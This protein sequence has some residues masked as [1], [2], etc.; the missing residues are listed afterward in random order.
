M[1][2][3]AFWGLSAL[4]L[5][6]ATAYAAML[7]ANR[8]G[9]MWGFDLGL[10]V[11][12]DFS[13]YWAAAQ[14]AADGR[15]IEIFDRTRFWEMRQDLLG[16][17]LR[18]MGAWLYPPH[19]LM[20]LSPLAFAPYLAGYALFIG[21]TLLAY[22]YAAWR[23]AIRPFGVLLLLAA[24]ATFYTVEMGQNGF[25]TAALLVPG[26]ALIARRPVSAGALLGA[27]TIKPTLGFLVLVALVAARAWTTAVV[28]ALVALTLGGAATLIY[29]VDAWT[30]LLQQPLT[31]VGDISTGENADNVRAMTSIL[32]RVSAVLGK[33]ALAYGIQSIS[34]LFAA[35]ITYRV[36][37]VS[38]DPAIR[39]LVVTAGTCLTT[40]YLFH[41]D[42]PMLAFALVLYMQSR[43]IRGAEMPALLGLWFLPPIVLYG[44]MFAPALIVVCALLQTWWRVEPI[45]SLRGRAT[46]AT[47]RLSSN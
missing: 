8:D 12:R 31:I 33:T 7:L 5:A 10:P 19:Y 1:G 26:C 47:T 18:F 46:W 11:G 29:G 4:W 40:P 16:R 23:L 34:A 24:P 21:G 3:T 20:L 27:L 45:R 2:T 43:E 35:L 39:A 9:V 38:T 28:A 13:V 37:R 22:L 15:L 32:P 42:L 6:F 14:A 17:E 30:L 25:L 36:F 44:P 41:Y